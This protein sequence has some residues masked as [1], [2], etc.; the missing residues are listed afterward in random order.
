MRERRVGET[1]AVV[2]GVEDSVET[3]QE[4]LTVDKVEA[5]AAGSADRANDQVDVVS[6]ASDGR[7]ESAL[8]VI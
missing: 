1:D 5:L 4:R 8:Y 2:R 3:L 6:D 7:V